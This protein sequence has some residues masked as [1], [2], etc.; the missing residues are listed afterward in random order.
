MCIRDSVL[1]I[2]DIQFIAGKD[3][4][5]EEFFHT[6]N[7]L[8]EDGKQIIVTS[9]RPPRDI[10]TL[11]QRL[12]TRFEWGLIA[13]VQPPNFELRIAILKNKA[14]SLHIDLPA[15]VLE[16]LAEN[17]KNNVRQLEGVI[18]KLGA[19]SFLSGTPVNMDIAVKCA[20]DFMTSGEPVTITVDRILERVSKKYGV[21]V[22]DIKSRKR[23]KAIVFARH[24]AIYAIRKMT[25]LSLPAIGKIIGRDHSTVL[26][27]LDVIEKEIASNSL[28]E[29]EMNDLIREI[30][31]P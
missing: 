27:S 22:E 18:K 24:V 5:Q 28:F 4:T 12:R 14:Q 11:E 1:L 6:F 16:F 31:A 8:Y 30:K 21:S 29:L 7:A 20:A 25:E 3:S 15:D 19:Q 13:D 23:V 26:S 2:D 9:D 10:K 17:L